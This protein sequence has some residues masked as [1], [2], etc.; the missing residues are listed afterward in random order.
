M[1]KPIVFAV[2]VLAL[3]P[4]QAHAQEQNLAG[5]VKHL[6][7]SVTLNAP[8]GGVNHQS[9]FFLGGENLT[10]A[11]RQL[12]VAIAAQLASFPLASSSGGFTFGL[13]DRG[14]V[15]PTSTTFGPS[16]AERAV[17]IGRNSSTS[18][19]RSSARPT[20]RSKG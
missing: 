16:F 12:N 6:F 3:L 10:L 19:T 20:I 14:E 1:T 13:N 2:T 15:V 9:H 7:D 17:T 4:T 5:M 11:T 18:G 8:F